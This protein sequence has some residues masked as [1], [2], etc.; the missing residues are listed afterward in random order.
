MDQQS[1]FLELL[2]ANHGR[3]RGIARAYA[4][5]DAEDLF[6]EILWFDGLL[7]SPA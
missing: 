3:W 5:Q 4:R 2:M 1:R 6:Q 7:V